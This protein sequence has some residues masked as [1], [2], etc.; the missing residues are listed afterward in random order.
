MPELKRFD[1]RTTDDAI[2]AHPG[3]NRNAA[4]D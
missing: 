4:G 1:A 3:D 2:D